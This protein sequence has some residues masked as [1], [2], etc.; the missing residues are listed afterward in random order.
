MASPTIV[1]V[2][3][4]RNKT[5]SHFSPIVSNGPRQLIEDNFFENITK[6]KLHLPVKLK[7]SEIMFDLIFRSK[8]ASLK[9]KVSN[10]LQTISAMRNRQNVQKDSGK[11]WKSIT[12]IKKHCKSW[13]L[14][15]SKPPRCIKASSYTPKN[16][17]NFPTTNCF[18]TN[19][20]KKLVY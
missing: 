5:T 6:F 17:L 2:E 14:Y 7:R 15:P 1:I 18:S 9:I 12:K 20:T 8:G 16:I 10:E 4:F 11:C 3:L 13:P 19:I